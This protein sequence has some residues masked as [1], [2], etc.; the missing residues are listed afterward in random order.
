ML[1]LFYLPNTHK[2]TQ[3]LLSCH[4]VNSPL[5]ETIECYG[6]KGMYD[7]FGG[8]LALILGNQIHVF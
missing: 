1:L 2:L 6:E 4:S 8:F 7:A 5:S 3:P